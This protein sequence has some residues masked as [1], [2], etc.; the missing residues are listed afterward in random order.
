MKW[1]EKKK[2][3]GKALRVRQTLIFQDWTGRE[4]CRFQER[5]LR[6]RVS[7]GIDNRGGERLAM[8]KKALI[9]PLRERWTLNV[10]GGPDLD[11]Q[12]NFLDHEYRIEQGP[13]RWPRFPS[14]GSA[15]AIPTA[16]RSS[17]ARRTIPILAAT[18]VRR[19]DGAPCTMEHA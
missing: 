4:L 2:V 16:S 14:A 15:C 7:M 19:H 10:R 5:M 8:V 17:R 11:I 1:A 12:G 3:D 6:V 13:V 18:V 9:T